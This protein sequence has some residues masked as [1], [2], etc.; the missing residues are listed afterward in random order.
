MEREL[1]RSRVT[2]HDGFWGPRLELA[3]S[4]PIAG[5]IEPDPEEYI[6]VDRDGLATLN[7]L[8]GKSL[9]ITGLLRMEA[10]G[11][12]PNDGKAPSLSSAI[13]LVRE[14][15]RA[16]TLSAPSSLYGDLME[17]TLYNAVLSG[18]SLGG[19]AYGEDPETETLFSHFFLT[20]EARFERATIRQETNF[21]WESL[22]C[23]HVDPVTEG[24]TF[25]LSIRLPHYARRALITVNGDQVRHERRR[26]GYSY[27]KREWHTGDV[28]MVRFEMPVRSIYC[29][30]SVRENEG[31]TALTCGPLIYC[32]EGADNGGQLQELRIMVSAAGVGMYQVREIREGLRKGLRS[33]T[34]PGLR[35]R[36]ASD[37]LYTEYAPRS[38][39]IQL[40]AIPY[41]AFGNG[42][43]SQMRIWMH[44]ADGD[45]M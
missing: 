11:D 19:L 24:D 21:P 2:I 27:I 16:I 5:G 14:A 8:S 28:V 32:F 20:S 25:Y 23:Y 12:L 4:V 13:R 37:H 42:E 43:K 22:I 33:I 35:M 30:T 1:E 15:R 40:T 18:M 34:V 41:F 6:S 7:E 17:R 10:D 44:E 38:E 31:C 36:A 45:R 29:N 9:Y 39:R 26:D 3:R